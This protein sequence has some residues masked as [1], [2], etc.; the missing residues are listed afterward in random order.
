M[1]NR[2]II[3]GKVLQ[4]L[5]AYKTSE[6]ANIDTAFENINIKY[7]PDLNALEPQDAVQLQKMKTKALHEFDK[8]IKNFDANLLMSLP[9]DIKEDMQKICKKLTD[10]NT[11]DCERI[12]ISLFSDCDNILNQYLSILSLIVEVAEKMNVI[13]KDDYLAKSI[14]IQTIN[15]DIILK[16][17]LQKKNFQWHT[18]QDMVSDIINQICADN[19]YIARKS[20]ADRGILLQIFR[21]CIF[22]N[23]L[24]N[25]YYE[26]NN[27][28]WQEDKV[29]VKDMVSD[30]LKEISNNSPITLPK[31]S[32][33]WDDDRQFMQKLYLNTVKNDYQYNELIAPKLQNWDMSRVTLTDN[34][35]MKMCICE[36][37]HFQ[38]IPIKVSLNE[39][40]ELSKRYSTPKSKILINGVLDKL[41]NELINNGVIKKSGRGLMD[42]K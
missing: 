24:F 42:N 40:I 4:Q 25:E 26:N 17:E 30:T 32:K 7:S 41:S 15:N 33:N 19:L 21:E 8:Y 3:R 5:Y 14:D 39:Y 6:G 31:I 11:Q 1:L 35:I 12:L 37:I 16:T 27:I 9:E 2:R 23:A 10:N 18:E 34:L 38:T 29:A 36:M 13:K 20:N 28:S 22:K